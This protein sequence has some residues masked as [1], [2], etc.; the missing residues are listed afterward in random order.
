MNL[1]IEHITTY[2]YS[3]A[4]RLKPHLL[5]L[6]PRSDAA[7]MLHDFSLVVE[8]APIGQSTWIDLDGNSPIEVWFSEEPTTQLQIITQ[9]K[10]AMERQNPYNF[11]L[12]PW[13]SQLPI[14]YPQSLAS[15]LQPYLAMPGDP[16][17]QNL[18]RQC[19]QEAAGDTLTFVR[20]TMEKIYSHCSYTLRYD[21][22]PLAAGTTWLEQ[23]GSCRDFAELMIGVCRSMGLAARFVSGYEQGNPEV[24]ENHL[25]AW[26]EVYLPGGGWRG[27]DPTYGLAVADR[28]VAL[29]ASTYP[30]L[31]MP[32]DGN[33]I[34]RGVSA[35]M[36]YELSISSNPM[37]IR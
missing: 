1:H 7:Q 20:L 12:A 37:A 4:V 25:H 28:H 35:T 10:V 32:V 31:T 15:Q 26:V 23:R 19:F 3:E 21:D 24:P 29:A 13:A 9:S 36:T 5:R 6:R 2:K 18:A 30:K 11:L 33:L 16:T 8:P 14:D 34:G 22:A 17:V 27:W